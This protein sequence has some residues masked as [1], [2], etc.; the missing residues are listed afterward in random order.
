MQVG[1]DRVGDRQPALLGAL[2]VTAGVPGRVER[3]R[4]PVAEVNEIRAVAQPVVDDRV[5]ARPRHQLGFVPA[6]TM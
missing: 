1:L 5:D 2:H 4:P 6:T 3:E